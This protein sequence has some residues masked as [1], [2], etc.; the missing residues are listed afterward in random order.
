M[1]SKLRTFLSSIKSDK[2]ALINLK[3]GNKVYNTQYVN[4]GVVIQAINEATLGLNTYEEMVE[5]LQLASQ[6]ITGREFLS[7][8]VEKLRC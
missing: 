8:V 2:E 1:S 7:Q 3:I 4:E 6:Y 5:A